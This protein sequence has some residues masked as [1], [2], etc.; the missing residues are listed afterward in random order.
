MMMRH[1]MDVVE[2]NQIGNLVTMEKRRGAKKS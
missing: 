1:F 2:Y